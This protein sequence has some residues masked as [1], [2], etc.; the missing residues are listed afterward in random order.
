MGELLPAAEIP[1]RIQF[2]AFE[3]PVFRAAIVDAKCSDFK[4]DQL[5][6]CQPFGCRQFL[7]VLQSFQPDRFPYSYCPDYE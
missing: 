3:L 1:D 7:T 6:S 2:I 5:R 4:A